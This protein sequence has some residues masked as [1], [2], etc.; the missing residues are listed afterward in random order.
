MWQQLLVKIGF[1]HPP[2]LACMYTL[3]NVCPLFINNAL[4]GEVHDQK[5]K[6]RGSKGDQVYGV[7]HKILTLLSLLLWKYVAGH[8][9]KTIIDNFD[10]KAKGTWERFYIFSRIPIFANTLNSNFLVILELW[11]RIHHS[12]RMLFRTV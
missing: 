10:F 1:C 6:R 8:I 7:Q 9:S 3:F 12:K 11:L 4:D 2:L 5:K